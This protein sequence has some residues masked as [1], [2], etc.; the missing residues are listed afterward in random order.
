MAE[1]WYARRNELEPGQVFRTCWDSIVKLDH[2]VPGDGSL[3]VV[4]NYDERRGDWACYEEK[5]EP[6]D[7][8]ER[9]ADDFGGPTPILGIR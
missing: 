3:W 9:L 4:E 7:L 8:E 6:H 2:R 1:D 5:V